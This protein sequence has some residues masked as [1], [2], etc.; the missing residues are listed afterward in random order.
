MHIY[1]YIYTYIS[2]YENDCCFPFQHAD[3]SES[4]L[5]QNSRRSFWRR[6]YHYI[7]TTRKKKV[8]FF[9]YVLS[10]ITSQVYNALQNILRS[11]YEIE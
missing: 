11:V 3:V 6:Y 9:N 5:P 10:H 8:A 4:I 1:I 7:N 2:V